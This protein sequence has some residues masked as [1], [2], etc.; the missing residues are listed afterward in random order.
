MS[1][2][3]GNSYFTKQALE[4]SF[5]IQVYML[6]MCTILTMCILT[7]M[8]QFSYGSYSLPTAY[9]TCITNLFLVWNFP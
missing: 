2:A 1:A 3:L 4:K 7:N 6:P 9:G 5:V 8:S